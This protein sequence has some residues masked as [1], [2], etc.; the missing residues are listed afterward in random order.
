MTV[1]EQLR[2]GLGDSPSRVVATGRRLTTMDLRRVVES[3]ETTATHEP[4][5]RTGPNEIWPLISHH[6]FNRSSLFGVGERGNI[7]QK[8]LT[9]LLA[10]DGLVASDPLIDIERSW[11][12]GDTEESL[13]ALQVVVRQVAQVQPLIEKKHL[14]FEASRPAFTD[15]SRKSILDLF[16]ISPDLLVF[17]NFEQAFPDAQWFRGIEE[18]RYLKKVRELFGRLNLEAPFMVSAEEGRQA[19]TELASA[20]IHVSWQ[21]AVCAQDPSCDLTLTSSLEHRIFNELIVRATGQFDVSE[22][23][24]KK[25]RTRHVNRLSMGELPNLSAVGLSIPDAI[26]LRRDNA[27]ENFR[28]ELRGAMDRLPEPSPNGQTDCDAEASFE[29][30]ML[31]AARKLRESVK[32]SSFGGRVKQGSIPAAVGFVS[33]AALAVPIGITP[34]IFAGLTTYAG[35]TFAQWFDGR[36]RVRGDKV[37]IR[38]FSSLGREAP[39]TSIGGD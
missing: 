2:S 3:R 11:L 5:A 1:L 29:E 37:A 39:S 4:F 10:H 31:E 20:V 27:F 34:S 30:Q 28:T 33:S 32:A 13:A 23:R 21:L 35:V 8:T 19:I 16:G 17:V 26:A 6:G 25:G 18:I 38:Y 36:K 14:K 15:Q 7:H 12:A 22:A 9:L 24:R